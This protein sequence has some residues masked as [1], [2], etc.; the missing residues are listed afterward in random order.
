MQAKEIIIK[1]RQGEANSKQEF[2]FL[3]EGFLRG[4]IKDYQLASWL[5]AV[6]LKGMTELELS[7]WT[8][9]MWRSGVTFHRSKESL[10]AKEKYW[11][12][13][14]STGGVGDKT[15]LILIPLVKTIS[16]KYLG[17]AQI[18]IPM[19]SGRG[20]GHTGG[21]LDKLESVLGFQTRIEIPAAMELMQNQGFFMMGQ[22]DAIAPADRLIYSLR[23]VTGTIESIP[24]IVSSIMSKKLSENLNGIIFDVKTGLGAFMPTPTEAK[25]LAEGLLS[26][27]KN[28]GLD[29]VALISRMDEPLGKKAG[30]FLEIEESADFLKGLRR[31]SALEALVVETASWMI[32]LG[33]RKKISVNAAK[34]WCREI[35]E[36]GE[37]YPLFRKMFESQGG[38]F[39]GF[40]AARELFPGKYLT[41]DFP[42]EKTGQISLMHARDFGVLLVELGGGRKTTEC[43]IDN[44]VGF[45]F[46][47]KVGDSVVQGDPL[48]RVYYRDP[49]ELNEIKAALERAVKISTNELGLK[50][51]ES[52]VMEIML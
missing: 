39:T 18:E 28:Q 12:D 40:E 29:A 9:A 24:L 36:T 50:K 47:K 32:F 6:F 2:I 43:Q 21:T 26:V 1:K 51:I 19:V 34:E 41:Y 11:L 16:E 45:E 46:F 4:E 8:E 27:A 22:T 38:D 44:K 33:A 31:D 30:N 20:L 5:M 48:L 3:I 42:A 35:I 52:V 23:D 37:A 17:K 25:L 49:K 15:S 14:H 10:A 7:Q 13:K